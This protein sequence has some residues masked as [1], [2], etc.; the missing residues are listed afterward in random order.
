[1]QDGPDM[2]ERGITMKA[3]VNDEC[4]GC[5][6]CEGTCP[7]VFAIGDDG[8][9]HAIEDEIDEELEGD[10]QDAADGCPVSAI[11]IA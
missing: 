11:E 10:A 1:M 4:I 3:F 8:L 9:A 2:L 6:L 7:D 5:G